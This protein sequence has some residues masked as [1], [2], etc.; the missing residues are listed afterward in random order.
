MS[1]PRVSEIHLEMA[2]TSR[3]QTFLVIAAL[4]WKSRRL[5]RLS[6]MPRQR[7]CRGL[8]FGQPICNLR[9]GHLGGCEWSSWRSDVTGAPLPLRPHCEGGA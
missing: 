2:V 7:A 4:A 5:P 6:W 9:A 8:I 3:W 1:A